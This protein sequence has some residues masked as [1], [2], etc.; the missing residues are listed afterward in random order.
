MTPIE[1]ARKGKWTQ[2]RF[3]LK[4]SLKLFIILICIEYLAFGRKDYVVKSLVKSEMYIVCHA[5]V[6]L[7]SPRLD[8]LDAA[9]FAIKPTSVEIEIPALLF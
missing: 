4:D 7:K 5:P 2:V 3:F 8:A 1:T 6:R 9:A